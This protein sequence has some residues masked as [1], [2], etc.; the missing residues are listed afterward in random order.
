MR[1]TRGGKIHSTLSLTESPL[2]VFYASQ[3]NK[4]MFLFAFLFMSA[5]FLTIDSS[6]EVAQKIESFVLLSVLHAADY[7]S[8]VL[9]LRVAVHSEIV[10]DEFKQMHV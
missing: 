1:I 10:C 9:L 2:A 3:D 8:L 7:Q 6:Q 4:T 5:K